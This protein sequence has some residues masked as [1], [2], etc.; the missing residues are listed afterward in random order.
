MTTPEIIFLSFFV[1]MLGGYGI[2]REASRKE[3]VR[4]K[5]YIISWFIL[6]G[7]YFLKVAS[8]LHRGFSPAEM[9]PF[10]LLAFVFLGSGI[11]ALL[12]RKKRKNL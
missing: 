12:N 2:Y 9:A 1:L 6:A 4:S 10:I 8:Y 5:G 3:T 7:L 11:A